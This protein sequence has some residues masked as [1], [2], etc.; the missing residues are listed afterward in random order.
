MSKSC[1]FILDEVGVGWEEECVYVLDIVDEGV[2]ISALMGSDVHDAIQAF[3]SCA[4]IGV[5]S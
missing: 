1:V 5:C 3:K 4:I 2:Y